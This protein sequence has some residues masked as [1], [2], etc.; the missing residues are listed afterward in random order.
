MYLFVF[1]MAVRLQTYMVLT[2]FY[3]VFNQET[4]LC[5]DVRNHKCS[6]DFNVGPD[7]LVRLEHL[8]ATEEVYSWF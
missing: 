8:A 1:L 7:G 2:C 6:L 3:K 5:A 4:M